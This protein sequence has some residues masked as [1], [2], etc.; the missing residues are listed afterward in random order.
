MCATN[1]FA[2]DGELRTDYVCLGNLGNFTVNDS[3]LR[4]TG[5]Y[6]IEISGFYASISTSVGPIGP[7]MPCYE[8]Q[9][10]NIVTVSFNNHHLYMDLDSFNEPIEVRLPVSNSGSNANYNS[11]C[12]YTIYLIPYHDL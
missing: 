2:K 6:T 5:R 1:L 7:G 12:Y 9:S 4:G 11:F 8:N 10:G 3:D